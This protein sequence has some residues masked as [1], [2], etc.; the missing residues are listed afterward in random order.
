M[1]T[2]VASIQSIRRAE[3]FTSRQAIQIEAPVTSNEIS[4]ASSGMSPDFPT[5]IAAYW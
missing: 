4:T 2:E 3:I 5:E 1:N